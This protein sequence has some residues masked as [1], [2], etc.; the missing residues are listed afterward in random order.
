MKEFVEKLIEMLEERIEENRGYENDEYFGGQSNAFE[1]TRRIIKRL[2]EEYV[3]ETNVGEWI[4]CCE[5]LPE[6]YSPVLV[7]LNNKEMCVFTLEAD[8]EDSRQ[9]CWE[10]WYGYH[11]K[12][13]ETIAWQPLPEPYNPEQQKEIPTNYYTERF[14]R[15]V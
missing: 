8:F 14:N 3:P 1:W 15:I 7:M 4:P 5:R 9:V 11:K 12:I 2:A 6:K 13:G 10:D